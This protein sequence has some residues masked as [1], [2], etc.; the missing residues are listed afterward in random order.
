MCLF[1]VCLCAQRIIHFIL[2]KSTCLFACENFHFFNPLMVFSMVW[3]ILSCDILLKYFLY[4]IQPDRT[5]LALGLSV[6]SALQFLE[7][8]PF[9][10]P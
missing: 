5:S 4:L 10:I 2:M 7:T 3:H 9:P 1:I 8:V 6:L